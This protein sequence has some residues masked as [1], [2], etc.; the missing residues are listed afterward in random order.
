LSYKSLENRADVIG[1]L[2]RK[3][4]WWEPV[5]ETPHPSQWHA[6]VCLH[7]GFH[8]FVRERLEASAQFV[9]PSNIIAMVLAKFNKTLRG[10]SLRNDMYIGKRRYG[11][12]EFLLSFM[13]YLSNTALPLLLNMYLHATA[14]AE[15]VLAGQSYPDRCPRR[16]I[17][18]SNVGRRE[19]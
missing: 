6:L 18:S 19:R 7:R 3:H 5:I 11:H 17:N 1:V 9:D 12:T 8:V 13:C 2:V 14:W 4:N 15:I 10:P 16:K